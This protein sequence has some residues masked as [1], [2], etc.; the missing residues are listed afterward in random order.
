LS[1]RKGKR[2]KNCIVH[3]N[4]IIH[5]QVSIVVLNKERKTT[6]TKC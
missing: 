3:L 2:E 4:V 5:L 6:I 1:T